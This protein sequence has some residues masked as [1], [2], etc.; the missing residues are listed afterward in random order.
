M[1]PGEVVNLRAVERS[2]APLIHRWLNEP[3]VMRGWGWGAAAASLNAVAQMVEAW[4]AVESPLGRP[5]ALIAETLDGD[6]VGFVVLR[7]DRPEAHALELSLLVGD[8]ERWGQGFG[9]DILCA[10]LDACFADWGIHRVGLRVEEDNAR[11]L[12]LYRRF[13]FHPEGR[14][15]QAAYHDGRYR[16]VLLFSLLADEWNGETARRQDGK[17]ARKSMRQQPEADSR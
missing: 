8:P 12:A 1:I 13:G 15:R 5:A 6:P 3:E 4:L 7:V 11:A 14:L 16:D 10:T 17:T 9:G 2:D